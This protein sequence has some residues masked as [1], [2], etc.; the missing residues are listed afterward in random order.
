MPR[1]GATG[2]HIHTKQAIPAP[3]PREGALS[4]HRLQ[5]YK[6]ILEGNA[7]VNSRVYDLSQALTKVK[8]DQW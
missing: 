5:R 3:V 1:V 8:Q 7:H 6:S 4:H 2:V